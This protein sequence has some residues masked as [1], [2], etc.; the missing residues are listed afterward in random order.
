MPQDVAAFCC[1]QRVAAAF[2]VTSHSNDN[3]GTYNN[4]NS[5]HISDNEHGSGGGA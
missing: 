2:C 5:S 3:I 1:W 4:N